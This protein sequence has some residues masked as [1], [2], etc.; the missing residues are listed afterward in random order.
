MSFVPPSHKGWLQTLRG[1]TLLWNNLKISNVSS[2]QLR[3][4]NQDSLENL[5]GM[6]RHNCGSNRNPTAMQFIAALKTSLLNGLVVRDLQ[7]GNCEVDECGFLFN[8]REFITQPTYNRVAP[9]LEKQISFAKVQ[10]KDIN[11]CLASVTGCIARNILQ[12]GNCSNCKGMLTTNSSCDSG[13]GVNFHFCGNGV[14]P[15]EDV[16]RL[17]GSI[18]SATETVLDET[19]GVGGIKARVFGICNREINHEWVK[20]G[21]SEHC[22]GVF[23]SI[24]DIGSTLTIQWWQRMANRRSSRD[25]FKSRWEQKNFKQ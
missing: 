19:A 15:T 12:N 18:V 24:V 3:W 5:F 16:L 11:F 8:M 14:Y 2:L 17:V 20:D 7:H 6:I 21:C 25:I 23:E 1:V 9:E 4:L 13:V 22:C 10:L